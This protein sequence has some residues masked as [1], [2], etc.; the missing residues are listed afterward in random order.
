MLYCVRM[1]MSRFVFTAFS[2]CVADNSVM[3]NNNNNKYD[4]NVNN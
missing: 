2:L 3:N 1:F 4:N